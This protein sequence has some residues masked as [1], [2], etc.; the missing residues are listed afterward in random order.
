[1]TT[2]QFYCCES[3]VYSIILGCIIYDGS[4]SCG[5]FFLFLKVFQIF[6]IPLAVYFLLPL[7]KISTD[8]QKLYL[9]LCLQPPTKNRRSSGCHH[10]QGIS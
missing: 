10:L 5:A 1:M 3:L 2:N 7:Q 8:L 9:A 4:S 6:F